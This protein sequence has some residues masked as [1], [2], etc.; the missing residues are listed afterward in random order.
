MIPARLSTIAAA[1]LFAA[2][3][4][5]AEVKGPVHISGPATADI[6]EARAEA[7]EALA[8][9][10]R[11]VAA[12]RTA[13]ADMS[14]DLERIESGDWSGVMTIEGDTV[15]KCGE[16]S[17]YP[18]LKCAPYSEADKAE[19]LAEQRDNLAEAMTELADAEA[20]LKEAEAE[21]AAISP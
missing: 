13:V 21:L 18:D 19:M 1:I 4:W 16:P 20:D 6:E 3:A 15:I 12:A 11:V 2:P 8:D 5:A 14:R 7:A 17:K 9:A 10:R